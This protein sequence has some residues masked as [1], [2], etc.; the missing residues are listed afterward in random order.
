MDDYRA[1]SYSNS[2]SCGRVYWGD[3]G[4]PMCAACFVRRLTAAELKLEAA[5][6]QQPFVQVVFTA[7]GHIIQ[8]STYDPASGSNEIELVAAKHGKKVTNL[9]ALPPIPTA[10]PKQEAGIPEGFSVDDIEHPSQY[11][12][13]VRG[14]WLSTCIWKSEDTLI[15]HFLDAIKSA[16]DGKE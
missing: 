7:T 14:K 2:C 12:Y 5:E 9:Y 4:Q 10:E 6:K 15:W 1:D 13:V 11:G 16:A 3:K 8:W